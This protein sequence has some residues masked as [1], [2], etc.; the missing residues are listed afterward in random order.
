[1]RMALRFIIVYIVVAG[2]LQA[3]FT[4]E[5]Q[6]YIESFIKVFP[7]TTDQHLYLHDMVVN[8]IIAMALTIALG[9]LSIFAMSVFYSHKIAGPI[10][11]IKNNLEKILNEDYN[12]R[13]NLREGDEFN[14]VAELINRLADKLKNTK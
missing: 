8:T 10:Y 1:M 9:A 11:V 12:I 4:V 5:L 13:P 2:I 14:E 6:K 7:V 3:F